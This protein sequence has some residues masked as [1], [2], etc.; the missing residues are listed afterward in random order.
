M[1]MR[2]DLGYSI[3][4][5][6]E[7]CFSIK[8]VLQQSHQQASTQKCSCH[9]DSMCG[10]QD[11]FIF[12]VEGTGVLPCMDIVLMALEILKQKLAV[13]RA[14]VKQVEDEAPMNAES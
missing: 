1:H 11:E 10:V 7:L 13:L 9:P 5:L 2:S 14:H 12:K 6:S 3:E 8:G 4:V